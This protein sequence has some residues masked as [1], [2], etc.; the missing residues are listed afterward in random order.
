MDH[1]LPLPLQC[2]NHYTDEILLVAFLNTPS[3][4]ELLNRLEQWIMETSY[5]TVSNLSI[6]LRLD[7]SCP[8]YTTSSTS[9]EC[10][11]DP[12]QSG[13]PEVVT[14][15]SNGGAVAGAL[16]G[17]ILLGVILTVGVGAVILLLL[18]WRQLRGDRDKKVQMMKK[19]DPNVG[20][21]L[22]SKRYVPSTENLHQESNEAG[23]EPIS[24]YIKEGS[25]VGNTYE[26]QQADKQGAA[27]Q[28]KQK[29]SSNKDSDKKVMEDES[30]YVVPDTLWEGKQRPVAP[31]S[32]VSAQTSTATGKAS[33]NT[34]SVSDTTKKV[35]SEYDVPEGIE[36]QD[37]SKVKGQQRES[38]S[39][40]QAPA[41]TLGQ[42]EH[43]Q[44]TS[45]GKD[46][47]KQKLQAKEPSK[48][49]IQPTEQ[50]TQNNELKKTAAA[51]V[52]GDKPTKKNKPKL[53]Q[54]KENSSKLALQYQ[55]NTSTLPSDKSTGSATTNTAAPQQDHTAVKSKLQNLFAPASSSQPTKAT[56]HV[57]LSKKPN[58]ASAMEG[59][60]IQH[61]QQQE[62]PQQTSKVMAM[63]Q[64][65]QSAV[66][67]G[68]ASAK[69][70]PGETTDSK[71]P[72]AA[73]KKYV[74]C[75]K[76]Q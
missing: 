5:V 13:I 75:M 52:Q 9:S 64:K 72:G 59:A 51:A 7:R 39:A 46:H 16:I 60:K 34:T 40:Q 42:K 10:L 4:E 14:G 6:Q 35:A 26:P 29:K 24:A 41:S 3:R 44:Y 31:R 69:A 58:A 18:W 61:Q 15:S 17:G 53:H 23:Y 1:I 66:G 25:G 11:Q 76:T 70:G 30:G 48:I 33:K 55:S 73:K 32:A 37:T 28:K 62:A 22:T 54:K 8:L 67:S 68:Q 38:Q 20:T 50:S 71:S 45:S 65:L 56:T 43:V 19:V 74:L 21:T 47:Q 27:K 36:H 12:T 57:K 49:T 2:S 63:A